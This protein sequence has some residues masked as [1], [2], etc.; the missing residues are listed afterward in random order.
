MSRGIIIFGPTGSGKTTLGRLVAE[1]LGFP[2]YDIDDSIWRTDTPIPKYTVGKK[3][4]A[5]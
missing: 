1:K 3:K 4:S 2:Y 5:D